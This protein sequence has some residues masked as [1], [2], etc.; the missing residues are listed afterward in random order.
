MLIYMYKHMFSARLN[1]V[2]LVLEFYVKL[3]FLKIHIGSC[4]EPITT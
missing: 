1:H 4:I 3:Y 2:K